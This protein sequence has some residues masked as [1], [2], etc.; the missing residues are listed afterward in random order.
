MEGLRFEWCLGTQASRS[1]RVTTCCLSVCHFAFTL[2]GANFPCVLGLLSL[3]VFVFLT[4]MDTMGKMTSS[5]L[6]LLL[7][8]YKDI[9]TQA[10]NPLVLMKSLNLSPFAGW[11]GQLS[12]LA[13][14]EGSFNLTI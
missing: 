13:A 2:V 12:V 3:S 5:P 6:D 11:N 7:I 9:K 8:H 4:V 10:Y 14:P 1:H